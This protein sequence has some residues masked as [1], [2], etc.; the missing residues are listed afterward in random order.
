MRGPATIAHQRFKG[1]SQ[2]A[3]S[4]RPAN[5][6]LVHSLLRGVIA[7]TSARIAEAELRVAV[8][9]SAARLA[10]TAAISSKVSGTGSGAAFRGNRLPP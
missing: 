4:D 7:R 6:S 8:G 3:T 5:Y 1:V 2:A 9:P 10:I